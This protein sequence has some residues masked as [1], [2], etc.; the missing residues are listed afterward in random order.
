MSRR[1]AFGRRSRRP[2]T[3]GQRRQAGNMVPWSGHSRNSNNARIG[4]VLSHKG[5]SCWTP[6]RQS[7]R[8]MAFHTADT[9]TPS[10]NPSPRTGQ[11]SG[12]RRRCHV[13]NNRAL[14]QGGMNPPKSP[15]CPFGRGLEVGE[16]RGISSWSVLRRGQRMHPSHTSYI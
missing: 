10:P 13:G 4:A 3:S 8:G 5:P 6:T 16:G 7:A 9:E 15:R 2:V 11:E 12:A 1:R 14:D